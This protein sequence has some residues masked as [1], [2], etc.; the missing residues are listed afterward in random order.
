[1]QGEV[2]SLE[3]RLKHLRSS[4]ALAT[5]EL[6]IRRRIVLGP[7]GVIAKALGSV[8]TKLFVWR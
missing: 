1:M 5:V 4:A 3:G 2:D 6:S 7:L 8:I